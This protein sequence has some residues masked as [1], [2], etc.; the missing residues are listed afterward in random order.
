[1]KIFSI[2]SVGSNE[3]ENISR[4]FNIGEYKLR[5]I[6]KTLAVKSIVSRVGIEIIGV[7]V[8]LVVT[9]FNNIVSLAYP[10]KFFYWVI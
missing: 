7:V 2:K 10:D 1:M 3:W 9:K 6:R 5:S 4:I 8:P